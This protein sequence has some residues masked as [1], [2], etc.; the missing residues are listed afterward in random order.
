[1]QVPLWVYLL[2]TFGVA[3]IGVGGVA[4]SNLNAGKQANK[5]LTRDRERASEARLADERRWV[6]DHKLAV[7]TELLQAFDHYVSEREPHEPGGAR[8][9]MACQQTM[10]WCGKNVGAAMQSL[11]QV[12][13]E[14]MEAR[15]DSLR[16]D[17]GQESQPR[18]RAA[19]AAWNKQHLALLSAIR[20]E[21]DIG[22]AV[23]PAYGDYLGAG[24]AVI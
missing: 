15:V 8:L 1:M 24:N 18:M 9:S 5:Q 13:A 10:L 4:L 6:R 17:P 12:C 11:L 19:K 2:T 16:D 21:L 14:L 7:Y 22:D 3:F 23:W 20:D